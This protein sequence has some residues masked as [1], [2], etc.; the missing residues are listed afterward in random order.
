MEHSVNPTT[1][2]LGKSYQ[3]S[4]LLTAKLK[5]IFIGRLSVVDVMNK[6]EAYKNY[7]GFKPDIQMGTSGNVTFELMGEEY[8][9]K[10]SYL[11]S[12]CILFDPVDVFKII[13]E[14]YTNDK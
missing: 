11:S 4:D 3:C 10:A 8:T 7:T 2:T 1:L 6:R 12:W 9:V 13:Y 5:N 14:L